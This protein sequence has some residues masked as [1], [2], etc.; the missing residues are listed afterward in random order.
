LPG[1]HTLEAMLSKRARAD[2]ALVFCSF[3]WGTT[4]VMVKDALADASVFVYI[5]VRFALA[6]AILAAVFY[7]ALRK[8]DRHA[9]WAGAQI[10]FFMLGG[11]IFQTAG[12]QFTSPSKAAFITGCAVVL[13]PLLLV[14]FGRKTNSWVW[15][16]AAAALAG[17][18]L[19]TVPPEGFGALNRGDVLVFICAIMFALQI[20]FIGR[21]VDRHSVGALTFLQVATTALLS[22]LLLPLFAVTRLDPPRLFW[23]GTLVFALLVTSIGSTVM[24]FS[25]QVWAQK[26]T[27]SSHAAILLS[28]EPVFA[29]LTSWLYAHERMSSRNLSG[30]VLILLGILFAELKGNASVASRPNAVDVLPAQE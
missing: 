8:L 30:G 17:L 5:A 28:L 6:A 13:V 12:L 25:F 11:Y 20:I 21:H 4:F 18:Y 22:V 10:G 14:F 27:S 29:A 26:H 24:G 1:P 2:L 7:A 23:T 19:L 3:V 15:A 9:L 16:G